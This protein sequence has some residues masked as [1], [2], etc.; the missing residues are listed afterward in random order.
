[1]QHDD[2]YLGVLD[3]GPVTPPPG[4]VWLA[5]HGSMFG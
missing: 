3:G 1:M 4:I 5:G 2:Y